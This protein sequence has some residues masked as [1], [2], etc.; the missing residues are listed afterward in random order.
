V[1]DTLSDSPSWDFVP[2]FEP[3][4]AYDA[5]AHYRDLGSRQR[6]CAQVARDLGIGPGTIARWARDFLWRDRALSYDAHRAGERERLRVEAEALVDIKWAQTRAD[7]LAQLNELADLGMAQLLHRLKNRRGELRPNE[8]TQ[9]NRLLLHFGNLANGEATE[10]V[11]GI[12]DYSNISEEQLK[13]LAILRTLRS[14]KDVN[15]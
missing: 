1:T 14:D 6:T 15:E 5:F 12:P 9:I 10:R 13:A 7:R 8:V 3:P 11:D 4:E 2:G